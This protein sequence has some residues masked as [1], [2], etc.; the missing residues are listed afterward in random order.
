MATE[1]LKTAKVIKKRPKVGRFMRCILY[2]PKRK[3]NA[4]V[5]WKASMEVCCPVPNQNAIRR[6]CLQNQRPQ[7]QTRGQYATMLH[8][9]RQAK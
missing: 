3:R 9:L 4:G 2:K 7:A 5:V 8:A 1:K 6:Q